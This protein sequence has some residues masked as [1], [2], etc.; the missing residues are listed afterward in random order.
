M[1][2]RSQYVERLRGGEKPE[3]LVAAE[4]GLPGPRGNL[5]LI[6]ALADVA[7]E[8]D[9][10]GW[11]V[12]GPDVVG[13]DEPRT[14][15]V[16]GGIVGLG[17]LLAEGRRGFVDALHGLAAD[18]RWRVREAV[19]MA[20]QRWADTDPDAA[21]AMAESWAADEPLVQRAAV[22]AVCEPPLLRDPAFAARA[23]ALVDAVMT[24][25]ARRAGP[26]GPAR[27]AL[28]KALG[29][30]WSVAIVASPEPGRRAFERWLASPDPDIRWIV[31]ENLRKDRLMR[32]DPAWVAQLT[33]QLA[34]GAPRRGTA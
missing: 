26:R 13:G 9:L 4:S 19:A 18:P 27:E 20:L 15:L 28:R 2:R 14:V 32:L 29:Y 11:A 16:T 12:L 22:A 10:V 17:R 8:E 7:P 31:R 6:Q 5:E 25:F 3:A 34:G 21:F 1:T 23:V 30:G 24:D 33:A